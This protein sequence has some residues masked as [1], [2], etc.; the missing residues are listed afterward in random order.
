MRCDVA[1]ECTRDNIED[2]GRVGHDSSFEHYFHT[3]I[4]GWN[5]LGIIG[6]SASHGWFLPEAPRDW[7]LTLVLN[8]MRRMQ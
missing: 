6:R 7:L 4:A 1:V 5:T 2:V 3:D 8:W